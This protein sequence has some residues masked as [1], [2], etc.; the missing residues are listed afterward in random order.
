MLHNLKE[1]KEKIKAPIENKLEIKEKLKEIW[2]EEEHSINEYMFMIEKYK[3]QLMNEKKLTK[4]LRQEKL[5]IIASKN[6]FERLFV[7]C[8]KEIRSEISTEETIEINELKKPFTPE[9]K[10]KIMNCFI[11][12]NKLVQ[13]LYDH[14][15][16]KNYS[17]EFNALPSLLL[18]LNPCLDK[19]KAIL[20]RNMTVIGRLGGTKGILKKDSI[21]SRMNSINSMKCKQQRLSTTAN[22]FVNRTF[23]MSSDKF[24]TQLIGTK[25]H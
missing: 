24:K 4:K 11:M 12:N 18:K 14:V 25:L 3:Q 9:E 5:D 1:D 16:T 17:K 7:E 20:S 13:V 2:D 8:V 15:F 19:K 6:E 21:Q 10:K 22:N 23:Y